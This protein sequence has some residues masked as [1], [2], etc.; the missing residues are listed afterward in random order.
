MTAQG[1]Q[2]RFCSFPVERRPNVIK[3][4]ITYRGTMIQEG[5]ETPKDGWVRVPPGELKP[6]LREFGAFLD[7]LN[8]ESDRG[9]VLIATSF[10]DELL[11]RSLEAFTID[12]DRSRR[13]L[14]GFGAPLGDLATRTSACFA[15]GLLSEREADD[16]DNL[17]RIRN[18][19]AHDIHV[20]FDDPKIAALCGKLGFAVR[21]YPDVVVPPRGQFSTAATAL[22]LNLTNRPH[23]VGQHRRDASV[24]P[25]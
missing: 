19:F 23:Y 5:A 24:W 1:V 21:N 17:R 20:S 9:V 10:I 6:H 22:I 13:M 4:I 12:H 7:E 3:D 16:A 11:R 14:D 18:R 2:Y 25:Y 8:R 15:L